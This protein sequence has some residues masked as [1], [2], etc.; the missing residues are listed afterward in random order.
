MAKY[1]IMYLKQKRTKA[2]FEIRFGK[3]AYFGFRTSKI[4]FALFFLIPHKAKMVFLPPYYPLFVSEEN[5]FL[6]NL[7]AT[8]L[9]K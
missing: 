1:H 4:N 5:E 2:C 7:S 3:V 6:L 9:L 8:E